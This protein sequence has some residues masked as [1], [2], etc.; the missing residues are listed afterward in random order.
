M[1]AHSEGLRKLIEKQS[2]EIIDEAVDLVMERARRSGTDKLPDPMVIKK[3][4][5]DGLTKAT[6]ETPTFKLVFK[7]VTYEQTKS[8]EFRQRVEASL[9]AH[10]RKQ[11]GNWSE[12]FDAARESAVQTQEGGA[13]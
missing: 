11:L 12:H 13:Q 3:A 1:L 6:Q 10:K 9:P 4:L 2:N 5:D 8:K 7:D